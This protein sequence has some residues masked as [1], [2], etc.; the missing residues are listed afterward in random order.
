[1]I[2]WSVDHAPVWTLTRTNVAPVTA[3]M[4]IAAWESLRRT[5]M[6]IGSDIDGFQ[7][8]HDHGHRG[9][10]V[11]FDAAFGVGNVTEV[12]DDER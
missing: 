1:M 7:P 9:H 8:I 2:P 6:P 12:L 5:L 10:H 3:A 4:P 11:R